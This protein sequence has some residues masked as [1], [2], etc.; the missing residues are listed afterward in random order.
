MIPTWNLLL[1]VQLLKVSVAELV[2]AN[3]PPILGITDVAIHTCQLEQP[4]NGDKREKAAHAKRPIQSPPGRQH[5]GKN[6]DSRQLPEPLLK[7]NKSEM[8]ECSC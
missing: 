2:S 8:S 1:G 7:S 3:K 4:C 5:K 6:E